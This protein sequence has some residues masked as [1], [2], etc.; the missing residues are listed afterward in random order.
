MVHSAS[1]SNIQAN[2]LR[3]RMSSSVPLEALEAYESASAEPRGDLGIHGLPNCN[4]TLPPKTSRCGSSQMFHR[5]LALGQKKKGLGLQDT[6]P[7][8]VILVYGKMIL[9]GTDSVAVDSMATRAMTVE[10]VTRCHPVEWQRTSVL[11]L[12]SHCV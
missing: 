4:A 9:E 8:L 11:C 5:S 2:R 7:F 12:K 6:I 3:A 1:S 10:K